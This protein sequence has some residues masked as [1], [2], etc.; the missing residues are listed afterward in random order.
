[1]PTKI[2]HA[3]LPAMQE[4]VRMEGEWAEALATGRSL[5]DVFSVPAAI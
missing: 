4:R 2:H 3:A 1:M 5:V